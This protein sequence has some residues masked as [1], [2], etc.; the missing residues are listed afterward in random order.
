MGNAN[1]S[2]GK[3]V[4]VG[5]GAGM[6]GAMAMAIYAMIASDS[7]G[8]GFFTPMYHIASLFISKD[9][10]MMSMGHA[11]GHSMTPMMPLSHTAFYFTFGPALLGLIIHMVTGAMYGAVFAI[12][13]SQIKIPAMGVIV[14]GAVYGTVVFVVS[15]YIGLPIAAAIFN[16]GDQITHMAAMVGT[17]TFLVEHILF[18]GVTAMVLAVA[19]GLAVERSPKRVATTVAH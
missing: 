18:G 19:A 17:G 15:A 14:I 16:S 12:A 11:M 3:S 6:I 2:L 4:G 10:M 8:K 5:T 9:S 7:D 1:P 13:V